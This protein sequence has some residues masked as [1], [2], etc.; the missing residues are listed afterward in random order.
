MATSSA[1]TQPTSII[2]SMPESFQPDA[3]VKG[4]P[5]VFSGRRTVNVSSCIHVIQVVFLFRRRRGV[6]TVVSLL[7]PAARTFVFGRTRWAR[8]GVGPN[9]YWTSPFLPMAL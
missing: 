3:K 4:K 6:I 9:Q 5:V 8:Y 2:T 1:A 7:K